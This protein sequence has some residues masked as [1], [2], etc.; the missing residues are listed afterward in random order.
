MEPFNSPTPSAATAAL[1]TLF[2]AAPAPA[3][4]AAPQRAGTK[5][6]A[7]PPVSNEPDAEASEPNTQFGAPEQPV[8]DAQEGASEKPESKWMEFAVTDETGRRRVRVDLN[9]Q[10]A[11]QRILPQAYGFRKMQAERDNLK[12]EVE[13]ARPK[14]KELED[15][16]NTLDRAFQDGGVEALV[17]LLGGKR[18]HYRELVN[19]E[20]QKANRMA[21]A[22]ESER[23]KMLLEERLSKMTRDNELREKRITEETAR[24]TKEREEAQLRSLESQVVPAFNK[25]RF[26][27][28]LGNEGQERAFDQAIWDQALR[29]LESLPETQQLNDAIIEAEFRKVSTAFNA[30]IGR[31]A[32][33]QARQVIDKTKQ[34]AQTRVAA[35]ATRNMGR[36]NSIQESMT[37][38]IQKGGIAGLTA[39][40]MDVLRSR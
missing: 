38:N 39:G 18:G 35:A 33:Q 17:D 26:A 29:N 14:L 6:A 30:A 40:L 36:P 34:A 24:A 28:K 32:N 9:D 7:Q 13:S 21:G 22:T 27:G 20:I 3:A 11:L 15:N 25:Y 12:K 19:Q 8:S 16:W 4:P 5:P 10:A 37:N 31:K 1:D 23:E 2:N